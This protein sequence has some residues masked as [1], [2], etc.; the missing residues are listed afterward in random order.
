MG[1]RVAISDGWGRTRRTGLDRAFSREQE[2]GSAGGF[3][4]VH[5]NGDAG[6]GSAEGSHS[7]HTP[8]A[9]AS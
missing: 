9:R 3:L 8:D 5:Q 4:Q 1:L 6:G 2:I 7:S